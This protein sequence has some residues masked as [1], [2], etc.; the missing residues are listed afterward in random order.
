MMLLLL[1]Q[2]GLA[3]RVRFD[4]VEVRPQG[5]RIGV[6]QIA[7]SLPLRFV[8]HW[9]SIANGFPNVFSVGVEFSR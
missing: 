7:D 3:D 2:T 4:W 8:A 6:K 9:G 1:R 5:H